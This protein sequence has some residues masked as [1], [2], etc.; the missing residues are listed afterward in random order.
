MKAFQLVATGKPGQF[1][2]A[3]VAVPVPGP[4]EVVVRVR[5]LRA[6]PLDLWLEE[7]GLPMPIE[8]PESP[9]ARSP[10]KWTRWDGG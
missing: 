5:R 1:R 3:D 4:E 9:G 7:G 6:E 10:G 2:M 8:F